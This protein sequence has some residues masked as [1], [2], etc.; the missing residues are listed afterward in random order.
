MN[1]W[2]ELAGRHVRMAAAYKDS[3]KGT[4]DGREHVAEFGKCVG[5]VLGPV[6]YGVHLGPEVDVQWQPS[7]LKYGYAIHQLEVI[8]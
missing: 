8:E 2:S 3:L 5:I 1:H 4:P 6:D 7:G